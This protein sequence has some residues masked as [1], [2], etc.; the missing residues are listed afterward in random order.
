MGLLVSCET[1][2]RQYDASGREIGS[3]F[4]CHCG[5]AV[6]VHEPKERGGHNA[7]VVRCSSCGAPAQEGARSCGYCHADFTLHERDL[8]TV[9]PGCMARVKG[10]SK[11]CHSCGHTL[12]AETAT[13]ASTDIDCPS[14]GSDA[15]LQARDLGGDMHISECPQCMGMWLPN[16]VF[17]AALKRAK[18]EA[19]DDFG[20]GGGGPPRIAR[21]SIDNRP[22]DAPIYRTCPECHQHMHRHNF[23]K[24][25]GIIIDTCREH[26]AWFDAEELDMVLEWVRAGGSL[27]DHQGSADMQ[28]VKSYQAYKDTSNDLSTRRGKGALL[29][30]T[31]E[32]LGQMFFG[33]RRY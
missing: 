8:N 19:D 20:I 6:T 33:G 4:R 10:G 3:R 29:E 2:Q 25:S 17:K 21:T 11:F 1:C 27:N 31:F 18:T 26:G 13:A 16:S 12:S 23:A 28:Q 30:E 14:C 7:K 24:R 15:R 5:A 22:A 32:M 9:C